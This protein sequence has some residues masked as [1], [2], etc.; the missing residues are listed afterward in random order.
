MCEFYKLFIVL[1]Y[2]IF[3]LKKKIHQRTMTKKIVFFKKKTESDIS[4][5]VSHLGFG[6]LILFICISHN[7]TVEND[8]NLKVGE[9]KKFSG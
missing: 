6:M 4:R 8:F 9:E 2:F 3:L 1:N 5:I 7:F